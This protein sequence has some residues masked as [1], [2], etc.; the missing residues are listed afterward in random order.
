MR[1]DL[2]GL[3]F[4]TPRVTVYLWSP[5]RASALEHKLFDAVHSLPGVSTE[6][7]G[8][9][10]HIHVTDPKTWRAALQGVCRVLKGW[11]EE[12]DTGSERRAYR[13][14]LE[15]DTDDNGYDHANEPASLWAFLR[16][17]L[18]RGGL[19]DAEKIEEVDLNGFGMRIWPVKQT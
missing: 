10:M 18:E 8:D 1:V 9:E 15:G 3:T 14:L 7:E 12:A 6:Q 17:G 2:Y 11:Q 13:W 16:L 4:E 5:W 19:E